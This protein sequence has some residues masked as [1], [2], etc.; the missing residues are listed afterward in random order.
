MS[1]KLCK[2]PDLRLV[3]IVG[4]RQERTVGAKSNIPN[5]PA[6]LHRP[7]ERG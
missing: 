6:L 4:R 2:I 5:V 7:S 3:I 1:L